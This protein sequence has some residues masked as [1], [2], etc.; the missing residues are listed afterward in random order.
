VK[1][2]ELYERNGLRKIC[3]SLRFSGQMEE[4]SHPEVRAMQE[5]DLPMIFDLD[6]RSFE[7]DRSIHSPPSLKPKMLA[8]NILQG[9]FFNDLR[10]LAP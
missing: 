2:V 10:N 4:K 7:A 3:R 6:R 8:V 1:A 9:I 5:K